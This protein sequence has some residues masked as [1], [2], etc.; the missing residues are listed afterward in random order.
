M[1][2]PL[3]V[4]DLDGTLMRTDS[5]GLGNPESVRHRGDRLQRRGRRCR[6]ACP[7]RRQ[8]AAGFLP[9]LTCIV[10]AVHFVREIA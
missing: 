1:Q 5:E 10:K 3:Y 2:K 4:T 9:F 8:A 6:M 7:E